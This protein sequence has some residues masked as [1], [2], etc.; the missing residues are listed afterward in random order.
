M[1]IIIISVLAAIVASSSPIP[2]SY[3]GSRW[4]EN[5]HLKIS[6]SIGEDSITISARSTDVNPSAVAAST[7]CPLE[8]EEVDMQHTIYKTERF[9]GE[10]LVHLRAVLNLQ[11]RETDT[12]VLE[13]THDLL[14]LKVTLGEVEGNIVFERTDDETDPLP[15]GSYCGVV[16]R[17][18][19]KDHY[20]LLIEPGISGYR[21]TWGQNGVYT[22]FRYTDWLDFDVYGR[23][24]ID[25]SNTPFSSIEYFPDDD[26]F[27]LETPWYLVPL[28]RM[29]CRNLLLGGTYRG[30]LGDSDKT[31]TFQGR[32]IFLS[33]FAEP[34]VFDSI[35]DDGTLLLDNPHIDVQITYLSV[36]DI[37][38]MKMVNESL[39]F[40][41][42]YMTLARDEPVLPVLPEDLSGNASDEETSNNL[43][44]VTKPR[45]L[46]GF[47]V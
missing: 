5:I 28:S 29:R 35:A 11:P 22:Q 23:P 24:F 44:E 18:G 40:I 32:D 27:T 10:I 20:M 14:T 1:Q 9:D 6:L 3:E 46:N 33:G 37:L 2:G 17:G 45:L 7:T 31:V 13:A 36:S 34:L 42:G 41:P 38:Y 15:Q 8:A 26:A 25:V 19:S 4:F 16:H 47:D 12:V 21:L 43:Q 39:I 30:I